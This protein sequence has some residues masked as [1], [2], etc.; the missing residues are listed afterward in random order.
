MTPVFEGLGYLGYCMLFDV[1][2]V[3]PSSTAAR[4][5]SP[6]NLPRLRRGEVVAWHGG[7]TPSS[8]SDRKKDGTKLLVV[9]FTVINIKRNINRILYIYMYLYTNSTFGSLLEFFERE[10][11]FKKMSNS[12][13]GQFFRGCYSVQTCLLLM[14]IGR[15]VG[16]LWVHEGSY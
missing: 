6:L 15:D 14:L 13:K 8:K 1:E 12:Q 10:I 9:T 2:T 4:F 16:V 11:S 5:V 3:T 7:F